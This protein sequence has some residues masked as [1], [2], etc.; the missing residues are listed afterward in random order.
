MLL[1]KS[2]TEIQINNENK[3]TEKK[4][5]SNAGQQRLIFSNKYLLLKT[6][7]E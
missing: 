2:S 4:N 1:S 3:A 5:Y 7:S 6:G